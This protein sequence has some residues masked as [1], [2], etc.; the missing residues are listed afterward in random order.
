[1][2]GRAL[3]Y[4]TVY[5]LETLKTFFKYFAT[6]T[7]SGKRWEFSCLVSDICLP[8]VHCS[9][10]V[11]ALSHLS[12]HK[13][14][15]F[16]FALFKQCFTLKDFS[17]S[18][19]SLVYTVSAN[20]YLS[21]SNLFSTWCSSPLSSKAEFSMLSMREYLVFTSGLEQEKKF[22]DNLIVLERFD[23]WRP[24]SLL[25]STLDFRT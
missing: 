2:H 13:H 12:F 11:C 5:G 23:S 1:M 10:Y 25:V 24:S 8:S 7:H 3:V 20:L 22:S 21:F 16:K 18:P 14:Q 17:P 19:H 6:Q 9:T 15:Y 4:M